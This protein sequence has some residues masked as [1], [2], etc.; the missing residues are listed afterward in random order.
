MESRQSSATGSAP[1]G[2]E[3]DAKRSWEMADNQLHDEPSN[4]EAKEG[5]VCVDGPDQVDVKLTPE[6]AEETS[7]RLTEEAV[8]ARG[9][10]RLDRL[11]HRPK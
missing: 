7:E 6:A 10:R 5:A 2:Y 9:Q 3:S 1:F 8:R 4:V 11:L